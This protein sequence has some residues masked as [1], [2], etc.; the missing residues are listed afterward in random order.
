MKQVCFFCDTSFPFHRLDADESGELGDG[1]AAKWNDHGHPSH[2]L[3]ETSVP[4]L[5]LC[6]SEL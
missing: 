4:S 5:N 6:E 1:K 3:Q 2:H